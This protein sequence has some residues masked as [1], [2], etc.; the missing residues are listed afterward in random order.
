MA[1]PHILLH[2]DRDLRRVVVA[3]EIF[4]LEADGGDTLVR[5]RGRRRLRDVRRLG[6]ICRVLAPAGIVRIHRDY[7]VHLSRVRE[8]RRREGT[9]GWELRLEP[10]AN[11]VL[12]VSRRYERALWAAF[13]E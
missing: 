6:E 8:I 1:P 2:L 11:R 4:F 12:P 13:G 9:R 3:S 5:L 10:P 7:A